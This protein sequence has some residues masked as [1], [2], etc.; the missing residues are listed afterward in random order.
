[1]ENRSIR[2]TLKLPAELL[3]A[4]DRAVEQ[5]LARSRNEFVAIALRHELAAQKRAE[6]DAAFVAMA[7]DDEYQSQALMISNEFAK[8]DWEAFQ[9]GE[10]Q[11]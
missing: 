5:G 11:K 8:A 6:I 4:I 10:S 2:T 1:M 9:L 7:D 3:E